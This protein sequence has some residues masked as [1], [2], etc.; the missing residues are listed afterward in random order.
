M[1]F[2]SEENIKNEQLINAQHNPLEL[3]AQV[4]FDLLQK[5]KQYSDPKIGLRLLS[6][7]MAIN[8]RT[9]KRLINQ[10]NRPGY[11]TLF[12]I[13]RVLFST[14]DE[15]LLIDLV[16]KCIQ[17]EIKKCNPNI[18]DSK[19]S[20]LE[21]IESHILYDKC[22][23]ELYFL[24]AT[25]PI[26]KEFVQFRFGQNGIETID[27]M[28]NLK[29]IKLLSSG[30]YILGENQANI[31][32][33]TIKRVGLS[34]VE[35]YLKPHE[36][37]V[38]GNNFTGLYAEGISEDVYDKWLQID[39]IAFHEKVELSK[40]DGAKGNIRAFTFMATDQLTQD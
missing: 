23:S 2:E 11:T 29:S 32:P 1:Q 34:L 40:K 12:K 10:E 16:P 24:C 14:S 21:D 18:I 35:K 36:A 6:D 17:D 25:G 15:S 39:E 7:K 38:G 4:S 5:L 26:S 37:E 3:G 31:S 22:F 13:Y 20:F 30:L 8:E 9:L 33:D 19:T 27:K 28:L